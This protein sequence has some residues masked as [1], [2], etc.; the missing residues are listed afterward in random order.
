MVMTQFDVVSSELARLSLND[1]TGKIILYLLDRFPPPLNTL[2]QLLRTHNAVIAGSF[3]FQFVTSTTFTPN[4]IDIF[5]HEQQWQSMLSAFNSNGWTS[6]NV[7]DSLYYHVGLGTF[8]QC[9]FYSRWADHRV[10]II[11]YD[12]FQ[13]SLSALKQHIDNTFDMDGCTLKWDGIGPMEICLDSDWNQLKL[14]VMRYRLPILQKRIEQAPINAI[15]ANMSVD[16]VI[17]AL[18]RNTRGRLDK[19]ESRG[20]FIENAKI[21]RQHLH[22]CLNAGK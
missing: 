16:C 4:D 18:T 1:D 2:D 10:N 15:N 3:L 19:Y 9:A 12:G 21:V 20:F 8:K 13:P 7:F 11:A 22:K 17:D 6:Y 14:K 5:I